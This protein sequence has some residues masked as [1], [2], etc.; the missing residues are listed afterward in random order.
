MVPTILFDLDGTL[1]D[2]APGILNSVVYALQQMN[3]PVL[4][5]QE[6]LQFIGPPLVYSFQTY[7]G[8]T[9]EEAVEATRQYRVYFGDKGLLENAVFDGV[10]QMLQK[11]RDAGAKLYIATS[12]PEIYTNRIL[13]HFD[14]MR[15]FDAVAGATL[16]ETRAYKEQVVAYAL[17]EFGIEPGTAVM[18]GDRKHDMH[19]GKVNGLRTVGVTFGY[20]SREELL[21]SGADVLANSVDELYDV[22][23]NL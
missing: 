9:K 2:P 7:S 12:K 23:I 4:P 13:E 17:E 5:R 21:E 15:Y 20:G 10:P 19:G 22:L 1:T 14:L 11:L 3:S 18:V 16:D 8:M 6:L